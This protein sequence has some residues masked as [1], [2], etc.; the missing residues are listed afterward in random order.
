MY[1]LILK[2]CL[3]KIKIFN[4]HHQ[5][6]YMIF[7]K[8]KKQQVLC[9]ATLGMLDVWLSI[10]LFLGAE[11]IYLFNFSIVRFVFYWA[12]ELYNF[13]VEICTLLRSYFI[14]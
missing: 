11:W 5:K 2:K 13:L 14:T 9:Y 7:D 1:L 4:E 10:E 6:F 12:V 8:L 3:R